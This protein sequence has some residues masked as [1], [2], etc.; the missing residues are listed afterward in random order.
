MIWAIYE[1]K[2]KKY[3]D[4][5]TFMTIRNGKTAPAKSSTPPTMIKW[6]GSNLLIAIFALHAFIKQPAT[7]NVSITDIELRRAV[8]ITYTGNH[9]TAA[10]M[11]TA[12]SGWLN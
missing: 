1:K 5:S 4:G 3:V 7:D 6:M 9:F 8:H 10:G 11:E 12:A 2:F